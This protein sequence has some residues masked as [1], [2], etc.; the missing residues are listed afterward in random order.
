MKIKKT[1]KKNLFVKLTS[2]TVMDEARE[3]CDKKDY[4]ISD[5]ITEA[6]KKENKKHKS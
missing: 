4:F 1:K 5:Y 3:I 6:V 2:D